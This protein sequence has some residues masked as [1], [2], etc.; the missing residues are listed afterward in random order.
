MSLQQLKAKLLAVSLFTV[1]ACGTF[2]L[3]GAVPVIAK[4]AS[5]PPFSL[6]KIEAFLLQQSDTSSAP[7]EVESPPSR[8]PNHPTASIEQSNFAH[9]G[10]TA[11][12]PQPEQ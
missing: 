9:Q 1:S 8:L 5:D 11:R 7:T 2:A 12:V 4:I 6:S 10:S 3:F